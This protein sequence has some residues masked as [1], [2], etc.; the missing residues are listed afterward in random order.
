MQ[1]AAVIT[2]SIDTFFHFWRTSDRWTKLGRNAGI[3]QLE[4]AHQPK[5]AALK[6]NVMQLQWSLSF[7]EKDQGHPLST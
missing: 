4:D 1:V 2:G 5:G 6:K 3:H 7:G